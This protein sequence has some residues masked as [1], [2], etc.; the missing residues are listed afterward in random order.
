ML[1]PVSLLTV[2][3]FLN[4]S[5]ACYATFCPL[6]VWKLI[7]SITLY[8]FNWYKFLI[9]ILLR[10]YL[11]CWKSCLQTLRW[12]L[13]WGSSNTTFAHILGVVGDVKYYFVAN[14]TDI[15]TMKEFWKLVKIWRN[16][17]HNRVAH[18][19]RHVYVGA[20]CCMYTLYSH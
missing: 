2:P 14:L 4:F 19:L 10:T 16:C 1:L 7:N 9:K 11:R 12:H 15:L 17:H 20:L 6:F 18:F 3:V 5:A 8:P 13:Q